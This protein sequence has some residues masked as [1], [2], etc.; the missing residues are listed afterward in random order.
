MITPFLK[1]LPLDIVKN[2]VAAYSLRKLKA[3][4]TKAIRI[5][6]SSDDS[7]LDIG[8][9]GIHLDIISLLS[10]I[11]SYSGYV[12]TWYD[13]SGNNNNAIQTSKIAQPRLVN[14]GVIDVDINNNPTLYF[15]GTDDWFDCGFAN[16]NAPNALTL[17]A[18]VSDRNIGA[19]QHQVISCTEGGGWSLDISSNLGVNKS[20]FV[21]Y[22]NGGYKII[23]NTSIISNN[24]KVILTGIFNRYTQQKFKQDGNLIG[25]FDTGFPI[26]APGNSTVMAIGCN[27]SGSSGSNYSPLN[28]NEII[29]F[30]SNLSDIEAQKL[31][32]NQAKQYN[33]PII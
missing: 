6:R 9:V 29:R 20:E 2:A 17:N 8:F 25:H 24:Q 12:T 4:A 1:A 32:H 5:R 30:N 13:Q 14:N 26:V 27:P 22:Y 21:V 7:E 19:A 28:I 31:E 33:L 11:G 3:T 16:L 23:Q 18:I 15:D 10:F